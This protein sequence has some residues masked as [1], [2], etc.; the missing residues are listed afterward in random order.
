MVRTQDEYEAVVT[1]RTNAYVRAGKIAPDEHDSMRDEYDENAHILVGWHLAKPVASL[2][3]M[4]HEPHVRWE[5]ERFLKLDSPALPP[6][7]DTAEITRVC[8]DPAWA[9]TDLSLRLFQKTA[10]EVL[11]L[12]KRHILGSATRR[13]LRLYTRIGCRPTDLQFR[14]AALGGGTHHIFVADVV[15]GVGG[16]GLPWHVWSVVWSD[17][18]RQASVAGLLPRANFLH[19]SRLAAWRLARPILQRRSRRALVK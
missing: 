17:V 1:L 4:A 5:H 10:L 9:G 18:Y 11:R 2:R 6:K 7:P 14:Y 19:A 16:Y 3:I 13:A 8:V 15:Q 12:G